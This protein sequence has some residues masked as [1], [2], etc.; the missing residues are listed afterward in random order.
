MHADAKCLTE[1]I[2]ELIDM[3]IL[4]DGTLRNVNFE[5]VTQL[6]S[7]ENKNIIREFQ[8]VCD[9]KISRK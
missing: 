3:K 9:K 5:M 4:Q 8:N 1:K 2:K 7:L 6:Q